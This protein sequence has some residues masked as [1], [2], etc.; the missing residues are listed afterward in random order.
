LSAAARVSLAD[1]LSERAIDRVPV[2][3]AVCAQLLNQAANH[4]RTATA[5]VTAGDSEGAFQLAYDA[6]RKTCLALVLA[7]GFRPKGEGAHAGTFEAAAAIAANFGS[8]R[9]IEDGSELRLV[10]NGAEY[11]GETVRSEDTQDAIEIGS[12]LLAALRPRIQQ[13]LESSC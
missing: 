8:R 6:C 5:G 12:E 1:L 13:I 4:L 2:D 3:A 11:R 7:T 9:M 10:R